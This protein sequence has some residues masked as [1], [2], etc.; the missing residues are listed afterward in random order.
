MNTQECCAG[1][2][3]HVVSLLP[4]LSALMYMYST[5]VLLPLVIS[6]RILHC[7]CSHELQ[8]NGGH[9]EQ[10]LTTPSPLQLH[11]SAMGALSRCFLPRSPAMLLLRPTTG[12]PCSSTSTVKTQLQRYSSILPRRPSSP[13]GCDPSL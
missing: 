13:A 9:D 11:P 8:A 1:Q 3:A 2:I 10:R 6:T 7:G 5:T 4:A 12:L